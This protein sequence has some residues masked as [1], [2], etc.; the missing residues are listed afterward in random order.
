MARQRNRGLYSRPSRRYKTYAA[1]H[2]PMH[3]DW[4]PKQEAVQDASSNK[5]V[6]TES[7]WG[8]NVLLLFLLIFAGG[9]LG[10][11]SYLDAT[12]IA[13]ASPGQRLPID[14]NQK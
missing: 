5:V 4:K 7:Y 1:E 9:F 10:L 8:I 3:K 6:P 14:V 2:R 13:A 11:Q 12:R